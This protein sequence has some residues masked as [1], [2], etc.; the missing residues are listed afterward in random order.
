MNMIRML[1]CAGLCVASVAA[2]A[3]WQWL[4]KDGRKVYSDQGPPSDV[5]ANKILKQPG[6]SRSAT[7]T[8]PAAASANAAPASARASAP[9]APASAAKAAASSPKLS[10]KDAEL[11]AKKK[12]AEEEEAAK[13][14]AADE[15]LAKDQAQNCERARRAKAAIDSGVRIQQTNAKGELEYLSD[16]GRVT[17]GKRLQE[18]ITADCK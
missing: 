11:E 6:G 12:Q 8:A 18:V 14:K 3:Q 4:D 9:A 5:P 10:G 13:K 7:A 17:E 16:T 2:T 15:K 1:L